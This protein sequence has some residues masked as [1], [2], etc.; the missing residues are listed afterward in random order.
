MELYILRHAIA[1][2]RGTEGF[3]TDAERPLT[4]KGR[5]KMRRNAE[6]MVALGLSFDRII[7]SPFVRA[8]QTAEIVAEAFDLVK[9]LSISQHLAV[10]G[11]ETELINEVNALGCD[12]I[13]LVGHEPYLGGLISVLLSG[14]QGISMT[15]KK[16]SLCKLTVDGLRHGKCATLDWLLTP[17]QLANIG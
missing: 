1:V 12:G 11:S 13:V 3:A 16:G 6:G 5:K 14:D 15:L 4:P 2:E 17:N 9:H 8:R 10:G 7:S